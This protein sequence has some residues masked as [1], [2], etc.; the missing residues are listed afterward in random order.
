MATENKNSPVKMSVA[1]FLSQMKA[2]T[3]ARPTKYWFSITEK[4]Q[5]FTDIKDNLEHLSF[6]CKSV[7]IGQTEVETDSAWFPSYNE[8]MPKRVKYGDLSCSFYMTNGMSEYKFFK[9]WFDGIFNMKSGKLAYKNTITAQ[10]TLAQLDT[11]GNTK[12]MWT[13][14]DVFP[15][16]IGQVNFK[17]DGYTES[18]NIDV[19]FSF[20]YY[21]LQ[22]SVTMTTATAENK[23][24]TTDTNLNTTT[25][26]PTSTTEGEKK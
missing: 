1:G 3:M 12:A 7:T 16:S 18:M 10:V 5:I 20:S 11:N 6:M 21:D 2:M 13:F 17:Y 19:S 15:K 8:D 9:N 26:T 24:S 25:T 4:P 22:T 14:H 23:T